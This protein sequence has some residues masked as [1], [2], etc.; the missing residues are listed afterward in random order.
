[1]P[2]ELEPQRMKVMGGRGP[3]NGRRRYAMDLEKGGEVKL[4]LRLAS[5]EVVHWC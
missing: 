5:D 2:S 4:G 1:M 3:K